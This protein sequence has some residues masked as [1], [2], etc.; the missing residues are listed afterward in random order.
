M[1]CERH[2]PATALASWR[3]VASFWLMTTTCDCAS[4]APADLTRATRSVPAHD[5][6]CTALIDAYTGAMK[7]EASTLVR[8]IVDMK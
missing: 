8:A 4:P 5:M 1:R 7:S 6:A 2:T 3:C